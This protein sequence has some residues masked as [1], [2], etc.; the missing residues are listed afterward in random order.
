VRRVS[1]AIVL[2]G[3][4][5]VI[6]GCGDDE[7]ERSPLAESLAALCEQARADT[8]ALGLPGEVGIKVMKP[9]AKIE[10]RLAR[11]IEKLEG[12]TPAE[13]EQVASL[14]KGFDDY[15]AEIAAGVKLYDAGYTEGYT[16]TVEG[17]REKLEGAEALATRMGAPECA[18]RPFPDR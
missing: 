1:L 12:T 17:A 18:V 5:L 4:A 7:P 11:D 8:E 10:R 13:K 3:L 6:G 2:V 15:W 16:I 14:A 9:T